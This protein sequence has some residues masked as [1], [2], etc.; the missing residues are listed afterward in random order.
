MADKIQL[1]LENM[2]PELENFVQNGVFTK[3]EIKKIIKKRRFYEYQFERKDVTKVE[4][5]KA[6]KYEKVLDKRRLKKKKEQN[7]KKVNYYDFH[8]KIFNYISSQENYLSVQKM[9]Y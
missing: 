3:N 5:F 1:T 8:C 2:I 9:S 4:Y 7:A 6:I